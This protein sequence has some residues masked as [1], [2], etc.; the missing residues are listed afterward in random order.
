MNPTNVNDLPP[1]FHENAT[2]TSVAVIDCNVL[3][4]DVCLPK[5]VF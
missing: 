3:S 5:A 4:I 2:S 1:I